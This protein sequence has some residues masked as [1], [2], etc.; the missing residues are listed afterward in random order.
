MKGYATLPE[1]LLGLTEYFIFYNMERTHQSLD[2]GTPNLVYRTAGGGGAS[3]VDKFSARN[4]LA[5]EQNTEA[6]PG[7][8][9]AAAC[10]KLSS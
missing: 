10:E 1:L 8:R 9:R 2:Y 7:Q 5:Q 6:K 4:K 3:I